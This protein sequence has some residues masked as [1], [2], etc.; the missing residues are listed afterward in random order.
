[1]CLADKE[2]HEVPDCGEQRE[3]LVVG[4]GHVRVAVPQKKL[5]C[6]DAGAIQ[7]QYNLLL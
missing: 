4:L 2:Q 1:M 7:W 6:S 3:L 5:S